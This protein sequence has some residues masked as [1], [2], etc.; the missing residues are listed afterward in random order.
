MPAPLDRRRFLGL[1]A[2]AALGLAGCGSNNGRSS[3]SSGGSGA[4]GAA[5][6]GTSGSSGGGSIA[7]WYHQYGEAGTQ[8]AVQRYAAA[9]DKA[10]VS[11]QW[12]PG[13]YD[14]KSAAALLTSGGPDVFEY[15]N[16]PSIDMIKAGQVVDLTDQ[17]AAAKDDFTPALIDRVTYDGKVWAIPQVT[18]MQLLVYRKSLL[19]KAGIQP[20]QTL[21]E[22][23]AAA[24]ALTTKKTKGLFLSNAGGADV[25]GGPILWSSGADYLDG[26]DA[27]AFTTPEVYTGFSKLHSLFTS[28]SLLLGAPADWSDPSAI[29]QGLTAMQWTGLWTVPTLQKSLGDD[30][31]VLPWPKN[32]DGG[33]PAVPVGAYGSCVSAKAKDVE[34][35]KAYVKWLWVDKAD[36]QE[37]FATSYGFHIPARKSLAEKAQKLSS[38]VA[39]DAVKLVNDYGHAQTP[40]LWT[41]AS[42]TAFN[43][44]VTR[45]VK[46]GSSPQKEL[47]AVKAKV[48]AEVARVK[49]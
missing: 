15:G 22:L 11:V 18:D 14:K 9:Y 28:G 6:A 29:T 35:A 7:Q 4:S 25:L 46:N 16:G 45:M 26:D 39:A 32:G 41:P 17:I 30:F 10:K 2:L 23:I 21:D 19:Q 31:G 34:A 5:S 24:K 13:D 38:G 42:G 49:G 27:P 44:A 12:I 20:P 48:A 33:K 40:L 3:G 47:A 1:S 43:D 37:D 8:Q 36:F